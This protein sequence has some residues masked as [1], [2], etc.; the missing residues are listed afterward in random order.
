MDDLLLLQI[1]LMIYNTNPHTYLVGGC[2]RDMLLGRKLSKDH[3]AKGTASKIGKIHINNGT[4]NR[5]VAIKDF[6][7]KW[8]ILGYSRGMKSRG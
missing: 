7:D 3:I 1:F 8:L 4:T 2:V 5:F 6:Q